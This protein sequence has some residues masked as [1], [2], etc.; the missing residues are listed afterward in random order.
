MEG[1]ISVIVPIYKVEKYLNRCIDS[2]INQTY[3][4]LEIILIDDGS[5]DNCPIICDEYAKNDSRVRV[6]HKKNGGLSDARNAGLAI[7]HGEYISFIDSDDYIWSSM[8]EVMINIISKKN[9]DIVEC[10]IN[11]NSTIK[12]FNIHKQIVNI[13]DNKDAMKELVLERDIHQV[14]WNKI[15]KRDVIKDIFFEVGKINED[16]FWTYKIIG[17]SKKVAKIN[18]PFYCYTYRPESIMNSKYN[19]KRLDALEGKFNRL[20]Y[21]QKN[22][23]DLVDITKKNF[24]DSC[25]YSYQRL[26]K[27]KN[28]KEINKGKKI[29]KNYISYCDFRREEFINFKF[30]YKLWIYLSKISLNLTCKIRNLLGI[31]V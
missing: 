28:K 23:L 25:L 14:V 12:E 17:N 27:N 15:Y 1:K 4:N 31:G 26:I 3:S 16:E 6:V 19:L 20:K 9:V 21:I 7:A 22:N 10:D 29:I 11:Y 13:Y 30:K 5:P 2:I 18:Q 8:Y 24:F